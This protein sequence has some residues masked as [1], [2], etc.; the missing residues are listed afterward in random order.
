[1]PLSDANMK[2]EFGK[3]VSVYVNCPDH[4]K[5]R[6]HGIFISCHECDRLLCGEHMH[7]CYCTSKFAA[8]RELQENASSGG[9]GQQWKLKR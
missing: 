6:G 3:E 1:M 5:K 9:T 7:V 4:M 8:A 2:C